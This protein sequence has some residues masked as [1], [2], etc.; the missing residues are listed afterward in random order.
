MSHPISRL[1]AGRLAT[2]LVL[3]IATLQA[4]M[5]LAFAW[6]ATRTAP[7]D[8]PLVTS[9]PVTGV[10]AVTDAV[11]RA[12]PGAF[13][14]EPVA[15]EAAAR[16]AI[17]ERRAYGAVVVSAKGPSLLVSSAAS[18]A[19]AQVL[20]GLGHGLSDGGGTPA[21]TH[22]VLPASDDDPRGAVLSAGLLPLVM[23]G[24]VA[25]ALL[26]LLVRPVRVRLAAVL[27][28]ATLGGFVVGL[29]D[30]VVLGGLEGSLPAEMAVV[31]LTILA[32]T[33]TVSGVAA[34]VGRIGIPVTALVLMLL[35]NPLSG[36][37]SAPEMLPRPWGA[38]GQLLPPG[39]GATALR[40][41]G[42]F[43]GAGVAGALS[44]LVLWSAAGLG[45]LGIA[46]LRERRPRR[47]GGGPTAPTAPVAARA[48]QVAVP[49]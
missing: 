46:L 17:R 36:A 41:V 40:G 24:V 4:L 38:L 49:G 15:D 42:F 34:L 9:G 14:I 30:H 8:V 21:L 26:A 22:D 44:V 19:V 35:G 13:E 2:A 47:V 25:G 16:R 33:S 43:Q 32:T 37:A 23:T 39:A 11:E 7:R 6:P 1:P 3:A 18:P 12:V 28:F 29:L 20:T 48:H 10:R 5:V 27:G 45:L 31:G